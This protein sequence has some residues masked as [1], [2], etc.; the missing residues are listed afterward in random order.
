MLGVS[1]IFFIVS[2]SVSVG[3]GVRI[4]VSDK[5]HRQWI[6]GVMSFRKMY[7]YMGLWRIGSEILDRVR[8]KTYNHNNKD[9]D[10]DNKD[11]ASSRSDR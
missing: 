2:V 4:T 1:V 8:T 11:F 7:G 9:K 10:K 5:L 6:V 3:V